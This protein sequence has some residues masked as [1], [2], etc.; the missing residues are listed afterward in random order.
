MY[1]LDAYTVKD[2]QKAEQKIHVSADRYL[3][4]KTSSVNTV[5]YSTWTA[6]EWKGKNKKPQHHKIFRNAKGIMTPK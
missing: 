6:K 2:K 4:A 3:S 1:M 5:L